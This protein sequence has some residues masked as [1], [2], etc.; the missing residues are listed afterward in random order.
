[1]IRA[2]L[3]LN[4]LRLLHVTSEVAMMKMTGFKHK[5][6]NHLITLIRERYHKIMWLSTVL[7]ASY[8]KRCSVEECL[9]YLD[10]FNLDL[11]AF[12]AKD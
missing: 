7:D 3:T 6:E 4:Q 8:L 5:G 2:K 12:K 10:S 11:N 1:M 9:E